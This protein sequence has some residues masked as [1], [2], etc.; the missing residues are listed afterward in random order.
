MFNLEQAIAEWRQQMLAAGIKS[1]T[2]LDEL[3]SHLRDDIERQ[4]QSDV[5]VEKAFQNAT[6]AM[7]KAHALKQEFQK[8]REIPRAREKL[9]GF[10]C[11]VLVGFILWM[12]GF[13]FSQMK[14]GLGEQLIAFGAVVSS[15][16]IAC[17]WRHAVSL[18]PVIENRRKRMMIGFACW[19]FGFT[20]A[21]AYCYFVLPHFENPLDPQ[22]PAIG[23]WALFPIATFCPLGLGL[24]MSK[25]DRE[26]WRMGKTRRIILKKQTP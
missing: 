17:G 22:I 18:L 16:L 5:N 13:T 9:M 23:F 1:P 21:S 19:L 8:V 4:L 24:M 6:E 15:L 26:H 10:I 11:A 7:G 14:L 3:E 12:S 20:C 25:Q 2:P